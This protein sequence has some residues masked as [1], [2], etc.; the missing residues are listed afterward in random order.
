MK[1]TK[2][3]LRKI[4]LESTFKG[5]LNHPQLKSGEHTF[6]DTSDPKLHAELAISLLENVKN[7]IEL[8]PDDKL[9]SYISWLAKYKLPQ[10]ILEI[11]KIG[12][13]NEIK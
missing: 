1:I 7:E 3:E 6:V 4:I 8:V 9:K 2:K 12:A 10:I 5:N 11:H 13:R